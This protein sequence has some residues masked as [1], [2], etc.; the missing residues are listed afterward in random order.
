MNTSTVN[1]DPR[2]VAALQRFGLQ[3]AAL[4]IAYAVGCA[5]TDFVLND[6]LR[7][8]QLTMDGI[9]SIALALILLISLFL[10]RQYNIREG[11]LTIV[12]AF[13]AS[14]II[15]VFLI[16]GLAISS[17]ILA[18]I[19]PTS[20]VLLFFPSNR[21]TS[22]SV[23]TFMASSASVLGD[24][25]LVSSRISATTTHIWIIAILSAAAFVGLA[26]AM[27]RVDQFLPLN[28]KLAV[29]ATALALLPPLL[30]GLVSSITVR[31]I[32]TQQGNQALKSITQQ[33]ASEVDAFIQTNQQAL[34]EEGKSIALSQFINAHRTGTEDQSL[35]Y[36]AWI[37]LHSFS[38]RNPEYII[39]YAIL[40][41]SGINVLDTVEENIGTNEKSQP[42]FTFPYSTGTSYPSS[43]AIVNGKPSI[44]FSAPLVNEQGATIGVVRAQFDASILQEIIKKY[45]GYLGNN[46]YGAILNEN[47]VYIA[48]G[49]Q[50]E[51]I[52]KTVK[53]FSEDEIANLQAGGLVAAG[54]RNEV[55]INEPDF[56]LGLLNMGR[57]PVFKMTANSQS[58]DQSYIDNVSAIRITKVPWMIVFHQPESEFLLSLD[59][60]LGTTTIVIVL[61]GTLSAFASLVL[62]SWLLRPI[63][64]LTQTASDIADGNLDARA[65][66]RTVDEIGQLGETFN[67]MADQLK[68]MLSTL[69]ARVDERTADLEQRAL[70][71]Q[72]AAEVGKAVANLRDLSSLLGQIV[73]LISDRFGFYHVG[74]FLLDDQ[75]ENAILRAANSQ[76]GQRMLARGHKLKVG[77]VG[78]VG[79]VTSTGK[80]RIAL[81][82]GRDAVFFDNPDLPETRSE[83]AMP[84]MVGGKILGALDVQSREEAAFSQ[85]DIAT[86]QV[87]ADQTAV[88]IENARLFAE[89]RQALESTR[90]AYGE[91]TG[92]SWKNL[93]TARSHT[94][95][96]ALERGDI[97][98][99]QERS[100]LD[101]DVSES[102]LTKAY[103]EDNGMM[104]KV[105]VMLRG[106]ALGILR[107]KK[108]EKATAW[109]NDEVASIEAIADQLSLSLESARLYNEAQQRARLERTISE[110]TT[111]IG[112]SIELDTI[113]RS[114]VQEIGK[115]LGDS[116]VVIQLGQLDEKTIDTQ[117]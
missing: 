56:Y 45:N 24:Y 115:A 66:I 16:K 57:T 30:L 106:R 8:W 20:L 77:Q 34:D 110:V 18:L 26:M 101:D 78:I 14:L 46:S 28:A 27:V 52:G 86:L 10:F 5:I 60:Q 109:T 29:F 36:R 32:L 75:G 4:L 58:D 108:G 33:I 19:V 112:S 43:L 54:R 31:D 35:R 53:N 73:H 65:E 49:T 11:A 83:M 38:Q 116:E 71:L 13:L 51:M 7:A 102:E 89:N 97:V 79:N 99:L 100:T 50:S 25:Y 90:L 76:G 103:V 22:L 39:S 95:Y 70:Q 68:E 55:Y 21:I 81:D 72:A 64:S 74:V 48:N 114:T 2:Q 62:S 80:A 44:Y 105:P 1:S 42:Y 96:M 17:S 61:I 3:A 47:Y 111:K 40:D 37:T 82:V 41:S 91:V 94:G 23:A 117:E 6:S 15:R 104:L 67:R 87:L 98:S 92:Q 88:A 63:S 12:S 107:L 93:M 9:V 69:E 113:L 59:R 85:E 84:L